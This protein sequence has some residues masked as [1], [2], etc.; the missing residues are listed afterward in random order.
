MLPLSKPN[1]IY[2]KILWTL[3]FLSMGISAWPVYIWGQENL[4]MM[5]SLFSYFLWFL[6]KF[7]KILQI[8]QSFFIY[9]LFMI[10]R[11]ILVENTVMETGPG[12]SFD[13]F[14]LISKYFNKIQQILI[15]SCPTVKTNEYYY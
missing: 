4:L 9:H 8:F 12:R 1:Q 10:V 3:K 2:V 13:I 11:N 5:T 14:I 15:K 6:H 7:I